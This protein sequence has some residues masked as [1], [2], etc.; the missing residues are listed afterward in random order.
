MSGYSPI[1][2]SPNILQITLKVFTSDNKC[3]IFRTNLQVTPN[4]DTKGDLKYEDGI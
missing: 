1:F 2:L 3:D 4:V